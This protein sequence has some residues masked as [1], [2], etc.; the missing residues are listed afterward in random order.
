M[1]A[2]DGTD[3]AEFLTQLAS[4]ASTAEKPKHP[5]LMVSNTP[6]P[7][8]LSDVL[9]GLNLQ[10]AIQGELRSRTATGLKD[11]EAENVELSAEVSA[12][13]VAGTDAPLVLSAL[14]KDQASLDVNASQKTGVADIELGGHANDASEDSA[15]L[16]EPKIENLIDAASAEGAPADSVEQPEIALSEGEAPD[17]DEIE[18]AQAPEI[19]VDE[20]PEQAAA[21]SEK[22]APV[23]QA[24]AAVSIPAA[25][26]SGDR[27]SPQRADRAQS[28]LTAEPARGK[29][30]AVPVQSSLAG[31]ESP[32]PQGRETVE[33]VFSV[34]AG[35]TGADGPEAQAGKAQQQA[36]AGISTGQAP[37]AAP[38]APAA[39]SAAA[40][41]PA[42]MTAANA[43]FV[44]APDHIVDVVSSRLSGGE[45]PDR[46][47]IQL[48]PP[49][50]GRVSIEFKFDGQTLQ[51]VA[52]T[53]ETPEAMTK[54]RQ[55]HAQLVQ[56]LEQHGLSARDMSFSQN[57]P[58]RDQQWAEPA[59]YG[60]RA[61]GADVDAAPVDT[62]S[63]RTPIRVASG[64]LNIKL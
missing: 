44:A 47:A 56:S 31:Q 15:K 43:I 41:A 34:D 6:Q 11:G 49:E 27:T 42:G 21:A 5:L 13:A 3:F 40:P 10:A 38:A 33:S 54:L 4:P 26:P 19:K 37:S 53:G 51:H 57:T 18:T 14:L 52:V 58:Q 48:D 35:S 1:A 59:Q 25:T 9:P 28:I 8:G 62:L 12:D 61:T 24:V 16:T 36:F 60:A 39:A 22:T 46:I 50:L 55:M 17:T 63:P 45:R 23:A 7:A 64:G 30:A 29:A 2:D 20:E 32:Q